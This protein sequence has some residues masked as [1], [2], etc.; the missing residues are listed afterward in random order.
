MAE[1]LASRR[2][3]FFQRNFTLTCL[4][5]PSNGTRISRRRTCSSAGTQ[6]GPK[7]APGLKPEAPLPG[8][9]RIA[10]TAA[11]R[12]AT[13]ANKNNTPVRMGHVP[14]DGAVFQPFISVAHHQE[15]LETCRTSP[16][17]EEVHI[18]HKNPSGK[19]GLKAGPPLLKIATA[20]SRPPRS[21][22]RKRGGPI[23]PPPA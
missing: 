8:V 11:G 18:Y 23:S 13:P 12:T 14:H 22:A 1:R 5:R 15:D 16:R 19:L 2:P 3:G 9:F 4:P 10:P 21:T 20:A 6:T 7:G 17:F